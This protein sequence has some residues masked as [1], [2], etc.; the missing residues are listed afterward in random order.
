MGTSKALCLIRFVIF[1]S[2][3][4]R[5]L[6]RRSILRVIPLEVVEDG[7]GQTGRNYLLPFRKLA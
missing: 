4:T 2:T 3:R 5:I 7:C 1:S 6:R